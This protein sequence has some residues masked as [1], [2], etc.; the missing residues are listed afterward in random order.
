MLKTPEEI[1]DIAEAMTAHMRT[2]TWSAEEYLALVE[3][4]SEQLLNWVPP[5]EREFLARREE[6]LNGIGHCT[7]CSDGLE[8]LDREELLAV[9]KVRL[10]RLDKEELSALFRFVVEWRG[11]DLKENQK[12]GRNGGNK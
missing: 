1:A 10:G 12:E 9:L 7:R 2:C 6:R 3:A 5:S 4:V 8:H 11:I